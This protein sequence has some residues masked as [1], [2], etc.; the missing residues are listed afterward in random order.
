MKLAHKLTIALVLGITLVMAGN[1]LFQ[2]R[3]EAVLF[4]ADSSHDQHTVGRVLRASVEAV[5]RA[6]GE[7]AAR[8]LIGDANESNTDLTLRWVSLAANP[9]PAEAPEV[10]LERL[11]SVVGGHETVVKGRLPSGDDRR[12]TYIPVSVGGIRRGALEVSESLSPE[13]HFMRAT[14]LQVVATT[15]LMVVLC[16]AI[17]LG[18]GFWF[19]G[20]PMQA[21][22]DKAR[23]VGEGDLSGSLVVRQ[24]DEIGELAAELNSMCARLAETNRQLV[25]A[26]EARIA[27]LEQLRHADRLKT[28]GHLASGVAHEL[29]TPLNVVSGRAKMIAQGMVAGDDIADNARIISEQAAR[30][31]AII[32]QLLD[33]SRRRGP[34]L[35]PGDL[36]PIAAR[37]VELLATLA[38]KRSVTLELEDTAAPVTAQIDEAQVQQ[39]LANLV[40]NGLQAMPHG[41]RLALRLGQ[42]RAAP[43]PDIGGPPA[44]YVTVTVEDEGTGIAPELL[45]RIFEPFFTTKEVGEG[46]GLGLSVAYGI[47]QEHGGW[48]EVDSRPG[49][50]SRFTIFLRPAPEETLREALG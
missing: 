47:V 13:R 46:T 12:I 32:R 26:T 23:R 49:E 20:R 1:A 19:V 4:D 18:L 21:L 17:A 25:A 40:V 3:R 42:R 50:G 37:T 48:I 24:R 15:A 2:V 38:R 11:S 31:A 45:P 29:G 14:E 27:A 34:R 30:I 16:A 10:P 22:C 43:P 41:G 28:V 39:V 33:F 6:D 9:V 7:A 35:G 5:W 44:D 8:R 36:R